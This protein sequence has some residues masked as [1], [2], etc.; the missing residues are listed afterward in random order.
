MFFDAYPFMDG[1]ACIAHAQPFLCLWFEV[2][3]W[4]YR[5][6]DVNGTFSKK[7]FRFLSEFREGL[8]AAQESRGFNFLA[9]YSN[10]YGY[11]G[12]DGSWAIKPQFTYARNFSE[13][14]GAVRLKN[15]CLG[16][17]NHEGRI[18]IQHSCFNEIDNFSDGL[19]WFLDKD[20]QWWGAIDQSGTIRIKPAYKS[21]PTP[22]V[23]G[24]ATVPT[25]LETWGVLERESGHIIADGFELLGPFSEGRAWAL[26][27]NK[28]GFINTK[29]VWV[30]EP[31]YDLARDYSE[32][33]AAVFNGIKFGYIDRN[34]IVVIPF[35][36]TQAESFRNGL[37]RVNERAENKITGTFDYIDMGGNIV[38]SSP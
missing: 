9:W 12:A 29:G 38:Y 14:L 37:A 24:M 2:T 30:V 27:G 32:G 4:Q 23:N 19:A 6:L 25:G 7:S 18:V 3:P 20:T 10:D 13:G 5:V 15:G 34:G 35:V 11:I 22:F 21:K 8:Q 36:F 1:V 26:S 28:K 33:L 17:V 31:K 16:F